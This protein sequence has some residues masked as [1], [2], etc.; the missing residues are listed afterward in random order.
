MRPP[1]PSPASPA[2]LSSPSSLRSASSAIRAGLAVLGAATAL[3]AGPARASEL[4]FSDTAPGGIVATGNTLGLSKDVD[5]NGPGLRDSI[6]TFVSLD[7]TVDDTPAN[8]A[9]PYPLGTT[10]DWH[11]NG[12]AAFL[13]LREGG[14]ELGFAEVLYAE[15]LWGG[16]YN[17]GGEDVTADLDTSV[18]LAADGESIQV[19]PDPT[20][21]L[22]VAEI[23]LTGFP[24]NYY[25]RSADVTAFVRTHRSAEYAVRG[26]PATQT[27]LINS[28]NA[29]G[30]TLVVA[31]RDDT[32]PL[33]NLTIFVGGS[34]VDEDTQ[35][36]YAVSGFCAPPSGEIVGR[37]AFSAIEGDA[38]LV[39]DQ[40]LI[41][42]ATDGAFVP[43][44][45]PNN[46]ANNFFCSQLNDP[47]GELDAAG[48]FGDV[49]H[50]AALGSNVAGGRQG[51]DV[52]SVALSSAEGHLVQG[53]RSAVLRAI[54]TGDSFVPSL[55]AFQ[56]DVN[57]PNLTTS[58]FT[59][60]QD[61]VDLGDQLVVTSSARNTGLAD[62]SALRFRLTLPAGLELESFTSDGIVGDL[63]G[64]P[65]TA[66]DLSAGVFEGDL[67]PNQERVVVVRLRVV[68]APPSGLFPLQPVWSYEYVT[69]EGS[70]PVSETYSHGA[71]IDF[72]EPPA[73]DAG[74]GNGDD[75]AGAPDAGGSDG[76]DAGP[77]DD[78]SGD[79]IDID[80]GGIPIDDPDGAAQG[81][82]C[83]TPGTGSAVDA[84]LWLL[85]L[86]GLGRLARRPRSRS[87]AR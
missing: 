66:A 38:N 74:T 53:Q 30:W 12:S 47:A 34:F 58:A 77:G 40:F 28:L 84:A 54:T 67:A 15:L 86:A 20:T 43:L 48:T 70:A 23:A 63:Q 4:R 51:W 17:Y 49:N 21:A 19:A 31:Y 37:A 73:P 85:A 8:P 81:C 2:S 76:T 46:P 16:S 61:A 26:V 11:H 78:H 1:L 71:A 56:I 57:A 55:A 50:D 27:D 87:S 65:V 22:T 83:A 80:N 39:G 36:D 68:G 32:E 69:C 60:D 9:N 82:G 13:Q 35:E 5:Q 79:G 24:V 59:P 44:A 14:T 45:G 41:A 75:D 18:T 42:P 29:A 7:A 52:T 62:A 25:L 3:V 6:G 64:Q 72:I 10:A 33:R